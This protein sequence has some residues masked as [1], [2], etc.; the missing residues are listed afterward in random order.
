MQDT[1]SGQGSGA[2]GAQGRRQHQ[3]AVPGADE[4]M[5][6]EASGHQEVQDRFVSMSIQYFSVITSLIIH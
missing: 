4:G 3:G 2:Q 5:D 1:R 6:R